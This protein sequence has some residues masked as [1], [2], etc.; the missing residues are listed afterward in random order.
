[1]AS[2][3]AGEVLGIKAPGSG[4]T[5][6]LPIMLLDTSDDPVTGE[7][8][9]AAGI[10]VDYT[11]EG[12]TEFYDF[13]TFATENWDE[14]GYGMYVVIVRQ[15]DA[16]ELA[17]LDT[18]GHFALYVKTDNT[19][20]D[21]FLFKVNPADA[22]RDDVATDALIGY[23]ANLSG[24]AVT[25]VGPTKTQMDNAHALLATAGALE[26]HHH[27][28]WTV[29]FVQTGASGNADGTT[30]TDA[31]ATIQ[32]ALDA[33][34]DESVI[35]VG[36]GTYAEAI[37]I[38]NN[39][40]E[41]KTFDYNTPFDH[42]T[43]TVRVTGAANTPTCT[44]TGDDVEVIGFDFTDHATG[45]RDGIYI[46]GADDVKL[47]KLTVEGINS[48]LR[49]G[50]RI[51][52]NSREAYIFGCHIYGAE[53]SGINVTA[54][55][56]HFHVE[57]SEVR[58]ETGAAAAIN[59][60]GA[61]TEGDI[62]NCHLFAEGTV[63]A[64]I[65]FGASTVDCTATDVACH[66]FTAPYTDNGTTNSFVNVYDMIAPA[67]AAYYTA[68]RGPYL[69][70]LAAANLPLS[71][72]NIVDR[73]GAI[74][75]T[76]DNTI[77]GYI[78]ALASKAAAT[79]SDIGGTFSPAADS[80]EAIQ[81]LIAALNNLAAGA[82]MDLID[83]PNATALVAMALAVTEADIAGYEATAATGTKFGEMVAIARA[84]VAGRFNLAQSGTLTIY[85]V[86]GTTTIA[87]ATVGGDYS[88]R[89]V[90]S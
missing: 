23:L 55:E 85:E 18:I 49:D 87:T 75:G 47:T 32:A 57:N 37:T 81:E 1:M 42:S 15:S 4:E 86:D 12:Q 36:A 56:E 21:T 17:T 14:I 89:T 34:S 48:Q 62:D 60:S 25:A 67:D 69:D 39:N 11:K 52:G 45:S 77:L 58:V 29:L 53:G 50:I 6:R 22:V 19:R 27:H 33:A 28:N 65:I 80:T 72:D 51:L 16:D 35:Y 78:K 5:V 74:T 7:A 20:G 64:G 9:N 46:N 8:Y 44:I 90:L 13:P 83:A 63:A 2:V 10:N 76:G 79:P 26:E 3:T 30:W 70:E 88:T 68:T 31:Y 84:L 54:A 59:F 24:G 41:L 73:I 40:I 71:I 82:E 66:N 38:A 61:V 43:G